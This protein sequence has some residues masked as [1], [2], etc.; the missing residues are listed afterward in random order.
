MAP[1]QDRILEVPYNARRAK[2]GE[3]RKRI[4]CAYRM[5]K[6]ERPI[7]QINRAWRRSGDPFLMSMAERAPWPPARERWRAWLSAYDGAKRG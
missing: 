1:R 3:V 5:A 2:G 4:I 7:R 6:H